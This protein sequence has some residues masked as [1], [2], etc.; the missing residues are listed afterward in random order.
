[1]I[2]RTQEQI[3]LVRGQKAAEEFFGRDLLPLFSGG[4]RLV[5]GGAAV[6]ASGESGLRKERGSQGNE[7]E[8][9]GAVGRSHACNST[10]AQESVKLCGIE[11]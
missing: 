4:D 6:G 7:R 9:T 3:D 5:V 8:E 1:M 10:N 11:N 2:D